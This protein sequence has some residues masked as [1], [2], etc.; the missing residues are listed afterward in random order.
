MS[1]SFRLGA[2]QDP[3][4]RALERMGQLPCDYA[5]HDQ[6]A[7]RE[8][9]NRLE[10]AARSARLLTY[11]EFVRGMTFNVPGP[12]GAMRR[13]TIDPEL[14][15]SGDEAVIQDFGRYLGAASYRDAQVLLHALLIPNTRRPRPPESFFR[16]LHQVGLGAGTA[17]DRTAEDMHWM[18][19]VG[20]V[21][22][23]YRPQRL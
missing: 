1:T 8:L 19:L 14:L 10:H 18:R 7:C 20:K 13:L 9:L 15:R 17:G 5:P 4:E 21:H 22:D 16:W 6:P 12:D 23:G 3:F 11:A 2:I